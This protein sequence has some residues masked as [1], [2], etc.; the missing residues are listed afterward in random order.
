[1]VNRSTRAFFCATSAAT[2]GVTR[3]SLR[4]ELRW[5]FFAAGAAV[6]AF[7]CR[8]SDLPNFL[9]EPLHVLAS[10][11]TPLLTAAR[12]QLQPGTLED[13]HGTHITVRAQISRLA[14]SIEC[15]GLYP[16]ACETRSQPSGS[17]P[18]GHR[19]GDRV[20]RGLE[21]EVGGEACRQREFRFQ[22]SRARIRLRCDVLHAQ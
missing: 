4:C 21:H 17:H 14:D 2:A 12:V 10:H 5:L 7:A 8:V 9:A 16:T 19:K 6:P 1:M 15:H 20:D 13:T 18:L 3:R 11:R 22:Q